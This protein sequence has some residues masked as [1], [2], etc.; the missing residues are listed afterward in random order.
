MNLNPLSLPAT[1][2]RGALLAQARGSAPYYD[3]RLKVW[4]VLDPERVGELLLDDRLAV[5][6]IGPG[7]A[8][9][10]RRFNIA[11]PNRRWVA[12][13]LPLLLNGAQHRRT[14]GALAKLLSAEKRTG[15]PWREAVAELVRSR[16][17]APGELEAVSG[18]LLPI[19]NTVFGNLAHTDVPYEPLELTRVFDPYAS[20]RHVLALEASIGTLRTR[21]A[22]AGV[23]DELIGTHVAAIIFGRDA[24]LASMGDGLIDF[25]SGCEGRRLD[26]PT[27]RPPRLFGG[28]AMSERLVRT[29]FTYAG[30]QFEVGQHV[31]IYFLGFNTL[32]ADTERT[33][34]F[35]AGEHSCLG[36][37]LAQEVWSVFATEIRKVRLV[38]R[39]VTYAYVRSSLFTMPRFINLELAQP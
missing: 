18:L 15:G 31:R 5:A 10:E 2:N 20:H 25:A 30:A 13:Q 35:G 3:D 6:E 21:L 24:L 33:G 14:R 11:L 23:P 37:S 38:L 16:F 39:S 7:T 28:V 17:A 9:L 8:E 22:E 36:R 1:P 26:D 4:V 27:S 29:S 19:I 12:E 34:M 32:E